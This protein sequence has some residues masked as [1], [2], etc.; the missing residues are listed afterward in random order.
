MARKIVSGIS[1]STGIS[2]GKA[3][4]ANRD[5]RAHLPRQTVAQDLVPVEVERLRAAFRE[6]EEELAEVREKVPAELMVHR[7]IIDSH[8]MMLKDPKLLGAAEKHVREHRLN[9]E[10]ALEKSVS[11]LGKAFGSLED[12]YIRE[13]M[14]DVRLVSERVMDQLLGK[15]ENIKAV[16]GRVII[17]AHDLTPADIVDLEINKIMAFATTR[18]GKTSH[19][20]IVARSLTIPALVGVAGLEDAVND[21]DFV[22]IDG[23]SGR[24]LV[25]PN[26]EEIEHYT[27]LAAR[28]ETYERMIM[29]GCHLPA[30]TID[31]FRVQ[32][33]ANIELLEE[34]T[35]VI[36][37]GGEGI[38]LYRTEYS[39]LNRSD[40]PTEEELTEKYSDLASIMAP[41]RVIFRTLDLGADK[42][43]STFGHMEEANPAMGLRAIRFC[44][45]HPEMFNTQLRAILRASAFGN[46][47]IMFPMISG[48]NELRQAKA[49]LE[50]AKEEL[51][52]EGIKFNEGIPVGIMVE[53]PGAVM[54]ADILAQEVD[55]FSIG[56]NDLIQY[57]LGIDRTNQHVSYLYQPLH[58]SALRSIKLVVDAA[59]EAGIEVSLCGEV[60]SDPFCVP[61]LMGMQ[62]DCISLSPQAIP[63]IKRIVRQARMDECR[64]L[65]RKAVECKTVSKINRLVMDRI[66]TSYP[67]ELAF[68]S[69]LLDI[70]E[71]PG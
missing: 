40:L 15:D 66:F 5:R 17:M 55:F 8:L 27:E 32:V 42:F 1:V 11:D 35:Q 47:A 34:V 70:D 45:K 44:L 62:I 49:S 23:I 71:L 50:K 41:R 67:E 24:L 60:A 51:R 30:E 2:I 63:G 57:N 9:A 29:R 18:G 46:A 4:F 69:S 3:F 59:H 37:N 26:E 16:Q 56:T 64:D 48:L 36:D 20:G 22:I 58:P 10:W 43:I 68:Y 21:G 54:I 6:V 53:L 13:R 28:F 33:L 25:E 65:L 19:T 12:I 61:I 52:S 31:G 14:Q 38:G 39:Y 7:Q